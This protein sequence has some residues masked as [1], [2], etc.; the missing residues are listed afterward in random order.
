MKHHIPVLLDEV[1]E[2]LNIKPEGIYMDC[3]I[4]FGGHSELILNQLNSRGK[5]IGLDL[6]PYALEQSKRKLSQLNHLIIEE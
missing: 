4:G 5:L 2:M 6:D 3:T 1:I